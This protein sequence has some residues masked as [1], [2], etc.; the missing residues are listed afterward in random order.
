[1][2]VR[3]ST[4]VLRRITMDRIAEP[5]ILKNLLPVKLPHFYHENPE[6]ELKDR[7]KTHWKS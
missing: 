6:T 1:M 2:P 7:I 3:M 4:L 5:N